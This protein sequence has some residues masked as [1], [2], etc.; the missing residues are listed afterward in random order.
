MY[1]SPEDLKL[2]ISEKELVQL[3]R[4]NSGQGFADDHVQDVLAEAIDQADSEIDG[5][6]GVAV[7][8]PLSSVAGMIANLSGKI[9]VYNLLRRRP[10]IPDHWQSEY[11]RCLDLL[12]GIARGDLKLPVSAEADPA[13]ESI[14]QVVVSAPEKR[15]TDEVWSKF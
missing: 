5:Y 3:C 11:K 6:I 10:S 7:R 9:A 1:S 2:L 4:D 15:F 8:L 14:G 12:K 13:P